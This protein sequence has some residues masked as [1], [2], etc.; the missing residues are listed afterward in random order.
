MKVWASDSRFN[1]DFVVRKAYGVHG[2]GVR[3]QLRFPRRTILHRIIKMEEER[4]REEESEEYQAPARPV[5]LVQPEPSVLPEEEV[6][7]PVLAQPLSTRTLLGEWLPL[8][9]QM[10]NLEL[11]Y[12][13]NHHGR[14]LEM[15]YMRVKNAKHTVLLC[16]AYG[17]GSKQPF[18]VGM[19][20]SQVWRVSPQVYGDG[21][22]FLF[23][24]DPDPH[25]W[26]W[27]PKL[28]S[29]A[30]LEEET[31]GNNATALLEQ[32]MVGTTS[33]ISMGGNPDGSAGLRLNED[34]TKGESSSAVGFGNEPLHGREESV[35][36]VGLVEV[37]GF[38][39]QM[40]GRTA[41][42]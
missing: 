29:S 10:T 8:T 2:K 3:R 21:G 40:D 41:Q 26:R 34:F 19:Y 27:K 7:I 42:H 18:I 25:C 15:F 5:G 38:V 37:Y 4:L 9:L 1:F 12:S 30:M 17:S 13:T 36:D 20:A 11:L 32:F 35:F 39:R 24:V 6:A 33:Y 14:S 28:E 16:E 31:A 23:R 22:C